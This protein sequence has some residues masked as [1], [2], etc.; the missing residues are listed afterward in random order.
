MLKKEEY[1]EKLI[2]NDNGSND[3]INYSWMWR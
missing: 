1:N 3:G 2:R